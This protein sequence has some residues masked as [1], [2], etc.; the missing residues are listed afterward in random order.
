MAQGLQHPVMSYTN[1]KVTSNAIDSRNKINLTNVKYKF[2]E[3]LVE[4]LNNEKNAKILIHHISYHKITCCPTPR[5]LE[6]LHDYLNVD[7]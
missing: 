5:F 7:A 6:S 3:Q 2:R 4:S 1:W